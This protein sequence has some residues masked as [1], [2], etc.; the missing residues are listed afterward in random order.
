M[1]SER[2]VEFDTLVEQRLVRSCELPVEVLRPFGPVDVVAQH[3]RERE[4]KGLA[5]PDNLIRDL[6][7][8][9]A[10]R[11]GIAD[12]EKAHR[13]RLHGQEHLGAERRRGKGDG[14]DRRSEP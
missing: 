12:D 13:A 6:V 4:W 5:V 8:L 3:D 11:P 10:A 1:I 2:G 9:A 14:D 7:L